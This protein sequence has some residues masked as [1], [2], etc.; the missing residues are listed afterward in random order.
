MMKRVRQW[1]DDYL[2]IGGDCLII[3]FGVILLI[4]F[5][6]FW[7][8][9]GVY[10]FEQNKVVLGFETAMAVLIIAWGINRVP[11]DSRKHK[12]DK[13]GTSN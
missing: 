5:A 2:E 12:R 3:A 13:G 7:I 10:I 9:G 8:Y 6:L 1:L 11:G 4:H